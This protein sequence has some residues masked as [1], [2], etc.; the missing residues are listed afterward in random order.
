M[1]TSEQEKSPETKLHPDQLLLVEDV[2]VDDTEVGHLNRT[3]Y[4][5]LSAFGF[6]F[7]LLST[8]IVLTTGLGSALTAGGPSVLFWGFIYPIVGNG[9]LAASLCEP[10]SV[11]P[12][13]G[14]QYR[15]TAILAPQSSK[16]SISWFC[17]MMNMAGYLSG[18]ASNAY[19]NG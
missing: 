17:G 10:F 14:G 11:Y 13:A 7:C 6:C 9:V 15:W 12:T 2:A 4:T 18:T 3:R 16:A 1:A 5:P 8:W 19:L